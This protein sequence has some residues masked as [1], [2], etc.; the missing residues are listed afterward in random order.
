[1]IKLSDIVEQCVLVNE[2]K[3]VE[4]ETFYKAVYYKDG[5]QFKDFVDNDI[6]NLEN[7]F[8]PKVI[9]ENKIFKHTIYTKEL[10][11]N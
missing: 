10:W 2:R 7:Y 11:Y 5:V 9:F 4:F 3:H 1:M 6:E 8:R